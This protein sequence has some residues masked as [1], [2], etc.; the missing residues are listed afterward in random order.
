MRKVYENT[1]EQGHGE[2]RET[3]VGRGERARI[4]EELLSAMS[5]GLTSPPGI[6]VQI[7][8]IRPP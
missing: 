8:G 7:G 2:N 4:R 3:G 6:S 1:Q 5:T